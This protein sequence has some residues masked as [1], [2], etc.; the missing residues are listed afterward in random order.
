[1][2]LGTIN[3][4]FHP[5]EETRQA[6]GNKKRKKIIFSRT[7]KPKKY[8]GRKT[9]FKKKME[10]PTTGAENMNHG[11]ENTMAPRRY[12]CNALDCGKDFSTSGHLAR[13]SRIHTGIRKYTCDIPG[14][15]RTFF[16]ADNMTQHSIA[17]RNKMKRKKTSKQRQSDS[18]SD[19][20]L[21]HKSDKH[22]P[23][24]PAS[25]QRSTPVPVR[26]SCLDPSNL[27]SHHHADEK[28]TPPRSPSPLCESL[29]AH[30]RLLASTLAALSCA[31]AAP[32]LAVSASKTSIA[33]LLE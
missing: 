6:L 31:Q 14:C 1:M 4:F 24:V 12:R 7:K 17:H 16:R 5:V 33:F 23:P 28:S 19:V 15:Q 18:A 22:H 29:S 30:E 9:Y 2:R 11:S 26:V 27:P 20:V 8:W 21:P 32:L 13:H 10:G 3:F 25:P